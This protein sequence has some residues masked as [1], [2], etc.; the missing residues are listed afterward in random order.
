MFKLFSLS[1]ESP[2]LGLSLGAGTKGGEGGYHSHLEHICDGVH[3]VQ[4]E[5]QELWF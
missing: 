4:I 3:N 5:C 2:E 1:I